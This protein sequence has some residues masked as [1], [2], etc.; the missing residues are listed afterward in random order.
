MKIKQHL[1]TL[2][3]ATSLL[4]LGAC[5]QN[6]R[7]EQAE[8]FREDYRDWEEDYQEK[9]QEL[10]EN[11]RPVLRWHETFKGEA[12]PEPRTV[13]GVTEIPAITD[14]VAMRQLIPRI[15]ELNEKHDAILSSHRSLREKHTSF[16]NQGNLASI[17]DDEW[18]NQKSLIDSDKE[19]MENDQAELQ[20]QWETIRGLVEDASAPSERTGAR[21]TPAPTVDPRTTAEPRTGN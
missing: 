9:N 3:L 4:V 12:I 17:S 7:S 5:E 21:T 16:I 10:E 11:R 15:A 2:G 8:S 20:D 19:R 13:G 6:D 1:F 14:T 18:E